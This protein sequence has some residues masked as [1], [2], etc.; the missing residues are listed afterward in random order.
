VAED[1]QQQ[2]LKLSYLLRRDVVVD[3]EEREVRPTS[4]LLVMTFQSRTNAAPLSQARYA[5]IADLIPIAAT[6]LVKDI[7]SAS[8]P[9]HFVAV[10]SR[11]VA[12]PPL[13]QPKGG[14]LR[15]WI[16]STKSA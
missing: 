15:H 10:G 16:Y 2:R 9:W 8:A 3:L 1:L 5:D 14:L 13:D 6:L 7:E 11:P 4:F 12:L